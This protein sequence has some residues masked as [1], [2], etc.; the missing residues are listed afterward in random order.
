MPCW[1]HTAYIHI[2][3]LITKAKVSKRK[4]G[5]LLSEARVCVSP[6]LYEYENAVTSYTTDYPNRERPCPNVHHL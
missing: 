2:S 3:G 6:L 1:V 4:K 5:V